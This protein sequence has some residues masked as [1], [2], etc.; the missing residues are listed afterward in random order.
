MSPKAIDHRV[1]RR[2]LHIVYRGVYSLTP[3]VGR[4]GRWLAAVWSCGPGACLSHEDAAALAGFRDETGARIEVSVPSPSER[5]T[6]GLWIHRRT[7][8][9]R[10]V[11][12]R[13]EIPVTT[14][15]QTLI[16]LAPASGRR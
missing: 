14:V 6:S 1:R 3:N 11:T 15:P 5:R 8:R 13:D 10:D 4:K 16:D 2:R 7:L 9:P 12:Y